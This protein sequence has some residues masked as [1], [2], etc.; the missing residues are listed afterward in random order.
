MCSSSFC[1]SRVEYPSP[2]S[3]SQVKFPHF[4][5]Y[6]LYRTKLHSSI[7]FAALVLLQDSRRTL[8]YGNWTRAVV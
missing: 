4:I 7:N 1:L 3:N 5:V 2:S 6:A 8:C